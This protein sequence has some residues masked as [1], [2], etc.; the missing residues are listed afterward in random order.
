M[1]RRAF[2]GLI[3]SVSC[4]LN[5][6]QWAT[7][8]MPAPPPVT[9]KFPLSGTRW[10][11]E[12]IDGRPARPAPNPQSASLPVVSF[13]SSGGIAFAGCNTFRTSLTYGGG[14]AL[15]FTAGGMSTLKGCG[16]AHRIDER[17]RAAVEETVAF[18]HQG[19]RLWFLDRRG[20][21]RLR[22]QRTN[23]EPQRP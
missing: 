16:E 22:L 20:V 23:E 14:T 19:D 3:G 6:P 15:S 17:L 11:V 8:Q 13:P 18:R 10:V 1:N 5:S 21:E 4:V 9:G 2:V 7:A 12:E